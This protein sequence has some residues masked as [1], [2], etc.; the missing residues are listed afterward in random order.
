MDYILA[1]TL[2]HEVMQRSAKRTPES[3]WYL[4][5]APAYRPTPG[6]WARLFRSF[7]R[8]GSTA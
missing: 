3:D 4:D 8:S 7:R 2:I 5:A 1:Y 6:L